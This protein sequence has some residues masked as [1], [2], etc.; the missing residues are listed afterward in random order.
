MLR[1]L[2]QDRA[3]PRSP[4]AGAEHS[5]KR[6][7]ELRGEPVIL[8]FYKNYIDC[9]KD[10]VFGSSWRQPRQGQALWSAGLPSRGPP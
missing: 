2:L 8:I 3:E 9:L 5:G 7:V 6:F 1:C 4:P 10:S